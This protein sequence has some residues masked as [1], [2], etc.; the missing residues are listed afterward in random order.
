M[1]VLS[2]VRIFNG[3]DEKLQDNMDVVIDN[4]LIEEI[5][6]AGTKS[7]E[8]CRV[9][10]LKGAVLSPGFIDCH[11]HLLC[12]ELP[13][14]DHQMNDVSAGGVIF[15]NAD[16]YVAYRGAEKARKTLHAGFTT[17]VDGGGLNYI[18]VAL[19][20]AINMGFVEGPH[21]YISGQQ[22]TA[23]PS[24]F[25]GMGMEAHGPWNIRQFVRRQIYWGVDQ[26]KVENCAPLRSIGRSMD[27]PAFTL[28]EIEALC[29]EAHS[30]GLMVSAHARSSRS[31]YESL[32]GG[33]DLIS[34]GTGIDDKC[35]DLILKQGK[36]LLP[37]L[38]SPYRDP[39]ER[40][41]NVRSARQVDLLR[42]Q[43]HIHWDS[44]AKAYK[45]G[46]K[47]ALSTDAGSMCNEQGD[48]AKEMLRMREI[49]MSN[50]DCLRAA[51]SEASKAMRLDK[52][53]YV[54]VGY[55]ADL[56]ALT[57]N[58]VEV[59]ET[60]LDVKLVIKS[61]KVVKDELTRDPL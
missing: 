37:T 46:V 49:G 14:K 19:K 60:C 2:N 35:I 56:V 25:R 50:I 53:G 48:N 40:I 59:L 55:T 28:E 57:D 44:I 22:L 54:K 6:P 45:A 13:D 27:K 29:D 5:L 12:D 31:I 10:D 24:H 1:L 30:G 17:V 9:L 39:P 16:S 58:P 34:H 18:E 20:D 43:G 15:S 42:S 52:I 4:E 26:V 61:G 36:Y 33:V 23:W 7:F 51:T 47:I 8:N 3:V 41:V 11:Q 38:A 32:Q 21:Y